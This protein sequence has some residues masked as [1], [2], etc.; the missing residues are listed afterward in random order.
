AIALQSQ[1]V[2]IDPG[3]GF[4][5]TA[6]ISLVT[7]TVFLMWLGEQMTER[8]IGN[9]ISMI[10]FAGIVAGLPS[11]VAG[12]LQL[13]NTG[14]MS[15]ITAIFIAVAVLL[16]TTFVVFIERGQRRITVNYAKR[17]QGNRLYA[18]QSSHLPLKL[19]MSGVIPPIFASSLILFPTT[20]GGWFGNS[21]HFIWLQELAA[22]ISPAPAGLYR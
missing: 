15:P 5:V 4:I 21:K 17:Q 7:G 20:I 16:V 18:A 8:G 3:F 6:V 19:N 1:S 13:V 22:L 11:A 2:V 10:I 12:T 9:G 14:Q